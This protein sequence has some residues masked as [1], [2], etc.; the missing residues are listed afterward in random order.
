MHAY[1]PYVVR[2][3]LSVLQHRARERER[4]VG[5]GEVG[6][7]CKKKTTQIKKGNVRG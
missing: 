6:W 1:V 7:S 4:G 2:D 5:G 3:M